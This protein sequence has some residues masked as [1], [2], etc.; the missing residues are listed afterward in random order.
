VRIGKE[1]NFFDVKQSSNT[2]GY[3]P[4]GGTVEQFHV[5]GLGMGKGH[6]QPKYNSNYFIHL[7]FKKLPKLLNNFRNL[8]NLVD[9][10]VQNTNDMKKSKMLSNST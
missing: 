5:Y 1:R 3:I 7:N 4:N 9:E 8:K 6:Q 10:Q 2:I